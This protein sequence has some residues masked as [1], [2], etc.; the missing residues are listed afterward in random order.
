M[1]NFEELKNQCLSEI[2]FTGITIG[3]NISWSINKRSRSRWG[4]CKK[5]VDGT[6]EIQ[7]SEI[8]L[9]DDRISEKACKETIIHEILHTCDGCMKH[10]GKWK[11]Y[12]NLMNR[13]YGYNIKRTTQGSE[14]GI[15]DYK[16]TSMPIKYV[17]TCKGCGAKIYRKKDSR[18]TRNYRNYMCTGCG[19]VAWSRQLCK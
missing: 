3:K 11:F 7:I 4:M 13:E 15:E 5:N 8:L 6:Y 14:K 12:A 17:F 10:T 16:S 2:N 18:F 9:K 1:K 19:A